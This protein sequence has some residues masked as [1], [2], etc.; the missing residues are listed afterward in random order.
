MTERDLYEQH[1]PMIAQITVECRKLT[2]EEYMDFKMD[3]LERAPE[4]IKSFMSKVFV[5]I[6]K[7]LS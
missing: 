7:A 6:E 4:D 5:V 2:E 3:T 1:I